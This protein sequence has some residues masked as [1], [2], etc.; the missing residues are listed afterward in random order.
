[1]QSDRVIVVFCHSRAKLLD[2]CLKSIQSANVDSV[3]KILV[4]YQIGDNPVAR[5][6][7]KHIRM[8][9]YL[10]SLN[11]DFDFPLG[12]INKNR[13]IGTQFAFDTL[14]GKLVL[15]IEED[16]IISTDSLKFIDCIYNKYKKFRAFRGINLGSIEQKS[17]AT[18]SGY[19]ILRFGI[20]GSA[21]VLTDRSWKYIKKKK[22]LNF[23]FQKV[24]DA[25]DARIEFYLKSGFMVTPNLSRNL[26]LGYGGTFAPASKNDPYFVKI[27]KSW[28][29]NRNLLDLT[30]TH[31][32]INHNWR[33][34][35]IS[36]KPINNLF[37]FIRRYLILDK[38]A[39]VTRLKPLIKNSIL[40]WNLY[41]KD[42]SKK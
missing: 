3:W 12:N 10:I 27:G 7:N 28:V 30:Y 29:G 23:D 14:G 36:Y 6:I 9:D 34:D 17:D 15:G 1:L 40:N 37:Y 38:F 22:L 39:T 8:I 13:Y 16:N 25:W 26:D 11:S 20:H 33:F 24:N 4:V 41:S 31:I 19:S 5:V 2:K 42:S 18:L 35:S 21:G 32:Q